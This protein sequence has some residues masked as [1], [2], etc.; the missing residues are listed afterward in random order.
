MRNT[1]HRTATANIQ[2]S[3]EWAKSKVST[4]TKETLTCRSCKECR[5]YK[6]CASRSRD[7]P[8]LCFTSKNER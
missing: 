7:Y 4:E 8:C 3:S 2:H 6:F 5:G 1:E